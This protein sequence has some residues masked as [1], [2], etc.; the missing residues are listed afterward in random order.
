MGIFP[1]KLGLINATVTE[2][3]GKNRQTLNH[4]MD[5]I[6]K[7]YS[8]LYSPWALFSTIHS[9]LPHEDAS[10]GLIILIEFCHILYIIISKHHYAVSLYQQSL[11]IVVD[12]GVLMVKYLT[13]HGQKGLPAS[14][15]PHQFCS[16]KSQP[17]MY[18]YCIRIRRLNN[19]EWNINSFTFPHGFHILRAIG[20]R[21]LC[22]IYRR[23]G[24]TMQ[25]TQTI[26]SSI[27]LFVF[28]CFL[29]SP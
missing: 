6:K 14:Y 28:R 25:G 4:Y 8:F 1:K 16:Y 19:H 12:C 9:P 20:C 2:R 26:F 29:A 11:G 7:V 23:T 3:W 17:E 27:Q 24:I 21:N 5:S 13:V 22:Q 10:L 18:S 15:W